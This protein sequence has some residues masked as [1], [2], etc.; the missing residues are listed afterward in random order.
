MT[1]ATLLRN[2]AI[3]RNASVGITP[4]HGPVKTG[5]LPLVQVRM[6][7]GG[8]QLQEGQQKAVQILPP[9]D[10]KSAVMTG[11]LPMVQVKMTQNGAQ[12]DDG[13]D[14]PVVIKNAK[15]GAVTMGGLPMLQVHMTKAGPQVQTL[16]NVQGGPPQIQA[17][18]PA[19]SAPRPLAYSATRQGFSARPAGAVGNPQRAVPA[20][21]RVDRVTAP[22]KLLPPVPQF[23]VDQLML[24]RHLFETYLGDLRNPVTSDTEQTPVVKSE[25]VSLAEATLATIDDVL[26]ATAVRAEAEAAV[27]SG[28]AAI[29]VFT[30]AMPSTGS[31]APAPSV[32][33]VAGP[34]NPRAYSGAGGRS[35]RNAGLAPRATARG[36]LP[37]VI[38]KMENGKSIVQNQAEVD[39][40][41]AAAA[42][43]GAAA[44]EATDDQLSMLAAENAALRLA[45]EQSGRTPSPQEGAPEVLSD[46]SE[47]G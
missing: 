35:Q 17:P 8:P 19:L 31:I 2:S 12:L 32:S 11:G 27:A 15:H 21:G 33:Y 30:Q 3:V 25:I 44:M 43:A 29:P 20:P 16:P 23:S 41:R 45:L 26:V 13:Q 28:P 10:S 46:G 39:Q 38:V 40:V 37:P 4:P 22:Q 5:E 6:A 42:M 7:P 34:V 47:Q 9:K 36:P 1:E 18:P 14:H 24:C